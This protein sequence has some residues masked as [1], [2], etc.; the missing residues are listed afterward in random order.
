MNRFLNNR[1]FI[2]VVYLLLVTMILFMFQLTLPLMSGLFRFLKAV[3]T[4]FIIA[5]IISYILNPI[6]NMLHERKVPRT[7]AVLLIYLS[8]I[9]ILCVIVM[10]VVPMFMKQLKE[11][12]E[13]LPQ[14]TSNV[15]MFVD[16]IYKNNEIPNSIREAFQK[17]MVQL[18]ET[19]T[20]GITRFV[21][22]IGS[23]LNVLFVALIVPF[24]AFYMMKDFKLIEST[25]LT[26]LPKNQRKGMIKLVL[27]IDK[28]LGNYVRGQ[29]IVCVVVGIFAY[30][31]YLLIDLPYPLLLA[32]GVAIFNIVP[33]LGPFLGAA[34]ALV[35]ASTV[36]MKMIL[37][38]IL[39]NFIIQTLESNVI[40]PQVVG[41]SLEMHPLIIIL[42]LL[43][44]GEVA[45]VVG[46]ILAVPFFAVIKVVFQHLYLYYLNRVRT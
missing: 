28:A 27:D 23:T 33:Y 12:N 6:V 9:F 17:A 46:L 24:V 2:A 1:L 43:V 4:P 19:L 26:L 14:L 32:S 3:L 34:P 37:L 39:V 13:F 20:L 15:Q 29:F 7:L 11:L 35:M 44:G 40:S 22:G 31:G 5:M 30:I 16:G 21:Q 38:V 45:G 41:K 8:F 42:A 10:N 36:S 25:V 18:E